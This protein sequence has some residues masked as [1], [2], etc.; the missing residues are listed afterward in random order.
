VSEQQ[1]AVV[2]SNGKISPENRHNLRATMNAFRTSQKNG[3]LVI[4]FH[5]GLVSR[6]E[7]EAMEARL[8]PEYISVG[9]LPIFVIWQTGL[10]ET[11]RNNW[12]EVFSKEFF[13]GVLERVLQFLVGKADQPIGAKGAPLQVKH[14]N[15][16]RNEISNRD[17]GVE[18]FC[19]YLPDPER[20]KSDLDQVQQRQFEEA[21]RN[22]R[23][24]AAA[25]ENLI[26]TCN[27]DQFA[28]ELRADVAKARAE[29]EQGSKGA[30]TALALGVAVRAF[31]GALRRFNRGRDHGLYLTAVEEVA[32]SVFAAK[33]LGQFAWDAMKKDTQDAFGPDSDR[34]GGSAI[35]DEIEYTWRQGGRPRIVLVGHSAGAIFACETLK[36]ATRRKA[37]DELKF[38]V[39]MLA[40]ACTFRLFDDTLTLAP[41]RIS[42]FRCFA[43]S[44]ELEQKDRLLGRIYPRSLLYLVSGVL[45]SEADEPLVGMQRF[46]SRVR[47]FDDNTF[48]NIKRVLDALYPHKNGWIW[49]LS[50]AGA[51]LN[52]ACTTHGG[53]DDEQT[54]IES[55]KHIVSARSSGS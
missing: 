53:F 54:T 46:H 14:T 6:L 27:L 22:D 13:E 15:L 19:T 8:A 36:A 47:P 3:T 42:E 21:I 45:E 39:V 1:C 37:P 29:R 20:M 35:L 51:G 18:P 25:S 28:P 34:F 30:L 7:A 49:S 10:L 32:K 2:L 50:S 23:R 40:P 4:H 24:I 55:I 11:L 52:S 41:G 44:D 38:D 16:I 48:P 26:R 12:I 33:L 17:L 9:A 43:M 31:M 5:G